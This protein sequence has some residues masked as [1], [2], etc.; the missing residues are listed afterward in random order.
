MAELEKIKNIVDLYTTSKENISYIK[1]EKNVLIFTNTP[2]SNKMYRGTGPN[3]PLELI[4]SG[5]ADKLTKS[6]KIYGNEFDGSQ[7]IS[8][9][10]TD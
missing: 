7:D 4:G 10:L 8:N 9:N 5:T 6:V 2:G 3:T 1:A